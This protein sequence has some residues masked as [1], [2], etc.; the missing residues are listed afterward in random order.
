MVVYDVADIDVFAFVLF[1]SRER[2]ELGAI[3]EAVGGGL[4]QLDLTAAG[5]DLRT[6]LLPVAA[7][8]QFA[9][10]ELGSPVLDAFLEC[11]Q[12]EDLRSRDIEVQFGA[13]PFTERGFFDSSVYG[14]QKRDAV[15]RFMERLCALPGFHLG[16]SAY[17]GKEYAH[18]WCYRYWFAQCVHDGELSLGR[19]LHHE[20]FLLKSL[21][22]G[23]PY[24]AQ[25]G[26]QVFLRSPG[27]RVSQP[28]DS[29]VC[30]YFNQVDPGR[31]M[32]YPKN[33]P[34]VFRA[35]IGYLR[36]A[37]P[38]EPDSGATGGEAAAGSIEGAS[39]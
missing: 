24:V 14:A 3:S 38:P 27:W 4:E 11:R 25:Y 16:F 19:L 34:D 33:E 15:V 39:P 22:I 18:E 28:S 20:W 29:S 7:G 36:A 12:L 9:P 2:W 31:A 6:E 1:F 17:F 13:P 35:A 30:V 5:R 26:K 32:P 37:L 21:F 8:G 23:V 10:C